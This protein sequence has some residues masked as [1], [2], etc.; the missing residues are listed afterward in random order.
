MVTVHAAQAQFLVKQMIS[1]TI[2]LAF[3]TVSSEHR[4]MHA[5]LHAYPLIGA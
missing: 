2:A 4:S 3:Y 5:A 1:C